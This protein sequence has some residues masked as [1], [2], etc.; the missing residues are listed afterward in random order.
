[1]DTQPL[2]R[3][4]T[5]AEHLK[6][7]CMNFD[8]LNK[9]NNNLPRQA[10]FSDNLF[11]IKSPLLCDYI[12]HSLNQINR[13]EKLLSKSP[14]LFLS[15]SLLDEIEKQLVAINNTVDSQQVLNK[16]KKYQR[17]KVKVE[18]KYQQVVEKITLGSHQ[19]YQKLNE[20]FEFERRLQ[21]MLKEREQDFSKASA[22]DSIKLQQEIFALHQRLS[23][24]RKAINELEKQIEFSESNQGSR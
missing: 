19:L 21:V 23:R 12:E 17:S 10:I 1:M 2:K 5:L 4:N 11:P 24:C 8:R 7:K 18:K 6:I 3:L 14:E 15:E 22:K 20:Y 13:L 16:E 9:E